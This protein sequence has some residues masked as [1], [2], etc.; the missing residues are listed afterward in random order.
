M[1]IPHCMLTSTWGINEF[2]LH[3]F[4]ALEENAYCYLPTAHT[5]SNNLV[6]PR[7]HLLTSLPPEETLFEVYDMSF[8][9]TFFGTL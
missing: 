4:Q 9:N 5:C 3:T 8:T 1:I 2:L 7:G 6:L